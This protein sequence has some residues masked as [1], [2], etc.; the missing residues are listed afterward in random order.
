MIKETDLII[1]EQGKEKK[2]SFLNLLS[3][4][5]SKKV[6]KKEMKKGMTAGTGSKNLDSLIIEGNRLSKGSA[7]VGDFSDQGGSEFAAYVQTLPEKIRGYWK[8]PSHL[9]NKELR[10]RIK[11]FLSAGGQ[12]L[13]LELQE[14]SGDPDFD[15][16]AERAIRDAAPFP[17]PSEVV[18]VRLSNSGIILGFPL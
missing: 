4:Y 15:A 17:K 9:M 7:L 3:D 6:D 18:G 2:K 11:V 8:L 10:C 14:S 12:L 5:S 16:R 1:K 13:K